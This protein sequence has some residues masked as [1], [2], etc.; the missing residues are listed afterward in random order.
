MPTSPI[1]AEIF[2]QHL[3][4]NHITH[5]LRKHN[6]LDYY[7]YL[8][9]ILIVYNENHT[10]MDDTLQEFNSIH[11]NIHYTIDK[12][13]NHKR[14][15]LDITINNTHNTLT[16]NIYRKPTTTDLIVHNYS[17]HPPQHKTATIR[18][19]IDRM[20][21]YPIS[22][23]HKTHKLQ[24]IKTILH[25]NNY[26]PQTYQNIKATTEHLTHHK[27]KNSQHSHT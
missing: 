24:Y 27:N 5:T 21:T 22:K 25:N 18:Y 14:N 12:E 2:L 23:E 19:L 3:E 10:N 17:C 8:D 11:L 20:N 6:I 16:F 1:F 7:R 13:T 26:P 9:D 4:H 15:Y